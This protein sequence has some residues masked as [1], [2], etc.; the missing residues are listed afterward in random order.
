MFLFLMGS[1]IEEPLKF[2]ALLSYNHNFGIVRDS[3]VCAIWSS[4]LPLESGRV[5]FHRVLHAFL[6]H[7]DVPHVPRLSRAIKRFKLSDNH[8]H[9]RESV[10]EEKHLAISFSYYCHLV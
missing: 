2:E 1:S 9:R 5:R 7:V 8:V 6:L 4:E 10:N 3:S